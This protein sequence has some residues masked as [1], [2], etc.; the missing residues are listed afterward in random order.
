VIG[1]DPRSHLERMAAGAPYQAA[2]PQVRACYERAQ[3]LS[4]ELDGIANE[5]LPA[6]RLVMERLFGSVGAGAVVTRDVPPAVVAVGNPAR[7]TR[8]L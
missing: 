4:R 6:R 5:D 7:V 8:T 3:A 1:D 2:D